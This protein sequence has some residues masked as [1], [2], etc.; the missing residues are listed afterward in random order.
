MSDL[1]TDL[2]KTIASRLS[3]LKDYGLDVLNSPQRCK[4]QRRAIALFYFTG[5]SATEPNSCTQQSDITITVQIQLCDMRSH[6]PA[7]PYIAAIKLLLNWYQPEV[8]RVG[9]IKFTTTDYTP[10]EDKEGVKWLY[11]MNF[12]LK[13]MEKHT[14]DVESA[15]ASLFN[16]NWE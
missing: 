9:A 4:N 13:V 8:G 6:Q 7:Y 16:A 1:L 14:K 15:I 10:Y 3:V 12:S 11:N 5:E 2:E